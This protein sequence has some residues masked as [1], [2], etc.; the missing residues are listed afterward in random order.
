[1]HHEAEGVNPPPRVLDHR[2]PAE[3]HLL[4]AEE[5]VGD[6]LD[7]LV[8]VPDD[9]EEEKGALQGDDEALPQVVFR[10][11]PHQIDQ[12]RGEEEAHEG[13]EGLVGPGHLGPKSRRKA[14]M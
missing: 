11:G 1:M 3:L 7:G 6:L 5:G 12:D 10:Q 4:V 13:K 2:R 14:W 8:D 9:G